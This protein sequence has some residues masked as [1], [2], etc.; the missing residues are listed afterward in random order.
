VDL[1]DILQFSFSWSS[2]VLCDPL[3]IRISHRHANSNQLVLWDRE[4]SPY[5]FVEC[6]DTQLQGISPC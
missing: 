3:K 5:N 1:Q 4:M 6:G 2:I